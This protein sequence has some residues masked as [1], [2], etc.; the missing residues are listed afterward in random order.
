[1]KKRKK[2]SMDDNPHLVAREC[3]EAMAR[4]KGFLPCDRN[5]KVCHAC[6]EMFDTGERRHVY[7]KTRGGKHD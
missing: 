1:M 5:C 6:V 3:D 2:V 4:S 7:P